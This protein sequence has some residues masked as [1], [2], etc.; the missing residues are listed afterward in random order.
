M[1]AREQAKELLVHYFKL[2]GVVLDDGIVSE[3]EDIVDLI[4]EASRP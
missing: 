2:A 4:I 1:V 3:I